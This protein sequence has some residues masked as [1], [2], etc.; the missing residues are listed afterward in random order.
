MTKLCGMMTGAGQQDTVLVFKQKI[1][2]SAGISH[3]GK[4][5]LVMN[6]MDITEVSAKKL[7]GVVLLKSPFVMG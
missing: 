1:R 2:V 3:S 6:L 7:L 5:G 4:I